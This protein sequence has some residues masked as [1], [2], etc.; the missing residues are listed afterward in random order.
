M[1][2]SLISAVSRIGANTKFVEGENFYEQGV[3]KMINTNARELKVN[4]F[5]SPSLSSSVI[6][7]DIVRGLNEAKKFAEMHSDR[8]ILYFISMA[9]HCT[10]EKLLL[11]IY[12]SN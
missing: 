9:L 5:P 1:L 7:Q 12:D 3:K 2:N 11:S 6:L 8:E 4:I 10:K